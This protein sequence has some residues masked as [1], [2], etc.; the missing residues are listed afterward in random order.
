LI[1]NGKQRA[2]Q[3]VNTR[4]LLKAGASDAGAGWSDSQI[5]IV[6]NT[7]VASVARTRQQLVEEA[8]ESVL[9]RKHSPASVFLAEQQTAGFKDT[10]IDRAE[11]IDGDHSRIETRT[12]TVIHDV[13]RL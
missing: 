2:R 13:A 3:L 9:T 4:I 10:T 11:T 1:Q 8:S 7:S 5:P 12:T 6:P